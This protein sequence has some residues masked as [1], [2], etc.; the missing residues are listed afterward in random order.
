MNHYKII[1]DSTSDLSAELVAELDVDVIPL[2]FT[3]DGREYR[4]TPDEADL[5]SRDFYQ[6]L[7]HGKTS[8]TSQIN[9]ETFKETFLPYLKAGQDVLYLGFSSALS[10]TFQSAQMAKRELEED[11][12]RQKIVLVDTL[13]GSMGEGLLV[14]NAAK[15]KQQGAGIEAVSAWVEEN[16]HHLAHWITV[17][18]LNHLK[19]GGRLSGSA[20]LFGTMLGIKPILH[21]DEDGRLVPANKVRGRKNSLHELVSRFK[22]TAIRPQE[23][24]VF[25]MHGDVPEDAAYLENALRERYGVKNI[26]IGNV[27]PVVGSHAGP[28][29]IAIVFLATKR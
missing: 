13:S 8:T 25:I 4:N 7:R 23:E 28:G 12:P 20:A 22:K 11:F 9:S 1:T 15:R 29:A 14:W 21:L 16:K 2:T 6:L 24:M 10:N 18:D 3:I 5:S 17:D 27:G 26:K 19:R